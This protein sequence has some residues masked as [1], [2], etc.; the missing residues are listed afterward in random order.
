M[1]GLHRHEMDDHRKIG[2]MAVKKHGTI[3]STRLT[4][5]QVGR[6]KVPYEDPNP[7]PLK[8]RRRSSDLYPFPFCC[9]VLLFCSG[10]SEPAYPP[11]WFFST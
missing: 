1:L 9:F 8:Y 5:T 11:I 3:V 7:A 2:Q 6:R 4:D 10:P